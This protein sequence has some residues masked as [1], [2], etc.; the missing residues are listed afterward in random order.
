VSMAFSST[1]QRPVRPRVWTILAEGSALGNVANNE[2]ALKG[3]T[4]PNDR[5]KLDCPYRANLFVH[6]H[7]GRCPRLTWPSPFMR[8]WAE[9]RGQMSGSTERRFTRSGG[10]QSAAGVRGTLSEN[11]LEAD[12]GAGALTNFRTFGGKA[13]LPEPWEVAAHVCDAPKTKSFN[14]FGANV[15]DGFFNRI[16]RINQLQI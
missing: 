8:K 7:R 12:I 2:S 3:Q 4:Q 13:T 10:L 1:S 16:R 6:E 14:R 11:Q 9:K 15:R 5:G